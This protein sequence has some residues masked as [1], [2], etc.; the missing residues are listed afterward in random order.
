VSGIGAQRKIKVRFSSHGER[1]FIADKAKL[2]I[3]HSEK[4]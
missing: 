4:K 3:V 1:T 2:V